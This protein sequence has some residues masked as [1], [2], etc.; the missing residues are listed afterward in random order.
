MMGRYLSKTRRPFWGPLAAIFD[1]AGGEH[2]PPSPLGWYFS[3][4]FMCF[5][6][7]VLQLRLYNKF[8]NYLNLYTPLPMGVW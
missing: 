7:Y 1:F 2:V 8:L 6:M 3:L 5:E 4:I